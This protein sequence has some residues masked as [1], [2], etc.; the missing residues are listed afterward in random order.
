[1]PMKNNKSEKTYKQSQN[2]L[3]IQYK[4]NQENK[5]EMVYL[6]VP[7]IIQEGGI[8]KSRKANKTRP[9]IDQEYLK[10]LLKRGTDKSGE[11]M[12]TIEEMFQLERQISLAQPQPLISINDNC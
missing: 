8:W 4:G 7:T 9:T 5:R 6:I 3:L 11:L 12:D 2:R 1:M 10:A